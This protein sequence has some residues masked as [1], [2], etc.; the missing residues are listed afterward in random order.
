M[1]VVYNS[2]WLKCKN[3]YLLALEYLL[4]H[5]RDTEVLDL[6]IHTCEEPLV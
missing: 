5:T 2:Y 3:Y 1:V 4:V 6:K